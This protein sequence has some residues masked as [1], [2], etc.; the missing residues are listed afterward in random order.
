MFKFNYVLVMIGHPRL[1][2]G[3]SVLVRIGGEYTF[4]DTYKREAF[5]IA[6]LNLGFT[7]SDC[8]LLDWQ[9]LGDDLT[10]VL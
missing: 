2:T 10:F 9:F 6:C 5:R 8:K 4:V 1:P 7:P 3:K